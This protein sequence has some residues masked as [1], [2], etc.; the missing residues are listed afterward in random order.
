[1][2]NMIIF[3]YGSIIVLNYYN[4]IYITMKSYKVAKKEI[5]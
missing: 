4:A 2:E 3:D 5:S 1:M